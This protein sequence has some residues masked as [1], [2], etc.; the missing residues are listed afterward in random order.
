[1]RPTP[2]LGPT[3]ADLQRLLAVSLEWPFTETAGIATEE[4][5]EMTK[6]T[7]LLIGLAPIAVFAATF[8]GRLLP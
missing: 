8:A 7:K 2:G 6:I 5:N 3:S 4:V 1:M